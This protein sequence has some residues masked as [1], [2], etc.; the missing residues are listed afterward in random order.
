MAGTC[1]PRSPCRN[2][3]SAGENDLAS[4][5]P[6]E[7]NVIPIP[8]SVMSRAP[9]PP[10]ASAAANLAAK[11]SAKHLQKIL[12]TI[13]EAKAPAHQ[14]ESLCEKLLKGQAPDLYRDKTHM[15]CYNFCKQCEDNFATAV[16]T[17][18]NRILFAATFLKDQAL[19]PRQQHQ[20]KL[21]DET[22]VLITWEK[23]KAFFCCNLGESKTFVNSIW[24]TIRKVS[25]Y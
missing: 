15:K 10:L 5:V 7:N 19:F 25:Q 13:L 1:A 4:A 6:I 21:A 8:T 17:E 3:S 24:S 18:M 11:Y 22:N 2:L 20:C 14:P 23:F 9:A 12:K 16:A